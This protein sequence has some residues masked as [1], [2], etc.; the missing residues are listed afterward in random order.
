[1]RLHSL[2]MT[3]FGP[4]AGTERVDFDR[5][6]EGGLFLIHGPTGAG[7][8][9]VLDAVCFALYG[10]VPGARGKDRSPK[11][12][13]AP[14]DREPEVTLEF[15]IQGRRIRVIRKPRWERPKKRGT[16]TV[17]QNQKVVV[18]EL[19]EGSWQGVTTRP[20]EAGQ[21]VGD[22]VGLTLTQFCQIVMLP[23]GD[24]ARF[25]RAKSDDRRKSLERIFNTRVFR[26]V[27]E[28][29][30]GHTREL[31]HR[32]HTAQ[33]RV[34]QVTG[35]IAEV[36]RSTVPQ[37]PPE[38]TA[39]AAELAMVTAATARDAEA[40]TEGFTLARERAREALTTGRAL[41]RQRERLRGVREQL[42][43]LAQ[44][45]AWRDRIAERLAAAERTEAVLPS[46][47]ARDNRRTEL[48]KAELAVTD[49][50][51][52][53]GGLPDL[54]VS[55]LHGKVSGGAETLRTAERSR[56]DELARLEQLRDDAERRHALGGELTDLDRRLAEVR[57]EAERA[58]ERAEA[59]PDRV[60]TAERE[61]ER[62]RERAGL[63]ET[64]QNALA[65]A[66]KRRRAALEHERL[67]MEL[68]RAKETERAIVDTAQRARD[69]AQD[70]R[71]RRI[72]Q[73]A[74][75]LAAGLAEGT[76]CAVCGSTE[77]PSLAVP[78][79]A[80]LVV[81]E[82]EEEAR[83]AAE[84]A[85]T[86][87]SAAE[88][89]VVRLRGRLETE[90]RVAEERTIASAD[91]EVQAERARLSEAR[92]AADERERWERELP[93]LREELR[94]AEERVGELTLKESELV[95]QRRSVRAEHDRLTILLDRARGADAGLSERIARLTS[96]A[97]LLRETSQALD[98]S[99][100]ATEEL[101]AAEAEAEEARVQA[102]FT[103]QA[104]VLE[105]ALN[106]TERADLRK[107]ARDF[108]DRWVAAQALSADPDLMAA[109][110]QEPPDLVA[111]E[112]AA[113]IA[114]HDADQAVAWQDRLT[115]RADRLG[116]L[117]AELAEE[118]SGSEPVLREHAVAQGLSTLAA[119]TSGD[120]TDG[121]RLSA[122][123]LAARLEQVV[124]AANDRLLTMSDGR[125]ELRYTVD[126]AAGDGQARSAG[127]LG[128][129]V[130]DSWTGVER[131]PATLSGGET[132]FSSLALALGLG[133]VATAEAGGAEID[134]LFVD[135]GFG[136]LD[137]DTL[138]EVLDV[139]DRLR[140]GGRAVGVV[141]HVADL[142]RRVTSRLTV[143]KGPSGSH[144][145]HHG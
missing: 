58:K 95:A 47:R 14:L 37:T 70:L 112:R 109:G 51:A 118:V 46:L 5:L 24:F 83:A 110:D 99:A 7:K 69:H 135:E 48:D 84:R 122:Y 30:G 88:S 90:A 8:T 94:R 136:T 50:L 13:H 45:Q 36:G 74:A 21:F 141:S 125:Y 77:H 117:R 145:E 64:A 92:T 102:G 59:L 66:E 57:A 129:R 82:Q 55:D 78:S 33:E 10:S 123:V 133:D 38:Q 12:D 87:R 6:G 53:V 68:E 126:K 137:E 63:M 19:V 73:M 42:T 116:D 85:T 113:A 9:S 65:L 103:D 128:M 2:A 15:T 39:W 20:D 121:V 3:A 138:E 40:L 18:T 54:D 111:L 35:R 142:R 34:R 101:R 62:V 127:G 114:E 25:L 16:G 75:E 76:A 17:T 131:D 81:A 130:V 96:E 26:N 132:F 139:L 143:R 61:L 72:G 11:S 22:L 71:E 106:E 119:G 29:L 44:Q 144:V 134:T 108:D 104:Q 89:A 93:R 49:Q 41:Q 124:A 105:S 98:R 4:F 86:D 67:T 120:N 140:D 31:A 107:R 79:E 100:R 28:W 32:T 60:T 97:D 91:Q 43:E 1:M 52:L 56:L 115:K 27:E 23:Q 80:G